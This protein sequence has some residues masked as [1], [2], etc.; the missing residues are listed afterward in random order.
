MRA[1]T[2]TAN[3]NVTNIS[4]KSST[5]P[6]QTTVNLFSFWTIGKSKQRNGG[7]FSQFFAEL[8]A[9]LDIKQNMSNNKW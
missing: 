2:A 3:A 8:L 4:F 7:V 1:S 5:V 9:T 6:L